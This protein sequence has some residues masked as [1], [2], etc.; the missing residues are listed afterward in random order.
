[1]KHLFFVTALL[2]LVSCTSEEDHVT[3][4]VVPTGQITFIEL[5]S[6]HCIP[7]QQ[8]QPIMASLDERY[9]DQ[10]DVVFIDVM[11]NPREAE[12]WRIRVMPTQVFLDRDGEE[13]HRHEGFYPEER[14]DS[15]LQSKGLTPLW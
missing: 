14:I 5:G 11:R 15:L 10:L 1:M 12:P 13:F 4:P 7:C 9:G 6:V 3:A 8:M 2:L